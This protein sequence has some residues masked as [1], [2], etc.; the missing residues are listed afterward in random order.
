[1]LTGELI[2]YKPGK[3]YQIP[4]LGL[5]YAINDKAEIVH[6]RRSGPRLVKHRSLWGNKRLRVGLCIQGKLILFFV[7]RLML[8]T[9]RPI[10]NP[11]LYDGHHLSTNVLDNSITNL[12]WKTPQDHTLLHGKQPIIY[13]FE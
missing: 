6:L 5:N 3:F 9:F 11:E 4:I 1:M 8:I 2:K 7:H 12:A 13:T 10:D